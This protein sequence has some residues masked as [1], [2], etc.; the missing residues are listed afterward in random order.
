MAARVAGSRPTTAASSAASCR[1]SMLVVEVFIT[2]P[3]RRISSS[4]V[5]S[6]PRQH[7]L[8]RM[9]RLRKRGFLAHLNRER[10]G[11][12]IENGYALGRSGKGGARQSYYRKLWI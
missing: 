5:L 11:D 3:A 6:V 10:S 2:E 4:Q 8:D 9:E 12:E 7:K 1:R